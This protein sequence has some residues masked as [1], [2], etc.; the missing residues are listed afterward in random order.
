MNT[1]QKKLIHANSQ[2]PKVHA[3]LKIIFQKISKNM[4]ILFAKKSSKKI[5]WL[6]DLNF[7]Q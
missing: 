1:F 4:Q 7:N 2:D 3:D 5:G 6:V